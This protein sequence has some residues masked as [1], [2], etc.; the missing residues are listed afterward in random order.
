MWGYPFPVNLHVAISIALVIVHLL[1]AH[2]F[3]M[4]LSRLGGK[5]AQWSMLIGGLGLVVIAITEG[6]SAVLAGVPMD[7]PEA[8][9]LN[10]GYGAGTMMLAVASIVGGTIIA[11]KKLLAGRGR[12]SVLLSGVFIIFVMIPALFMG[13]GTLA[14]LALTGWSLFYVWIGMA[15]GRTTKKASIRREK[16]GIKSKDATP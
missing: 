4:G 3:F 8:A 10:N 12:W 14:Y 11:R 15:L 16:R 1:K 5:A 2:G 13:R 7:S 9:N 6:F